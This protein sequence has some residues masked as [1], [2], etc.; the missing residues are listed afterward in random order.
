MVV[1]MVFRVDFSMLLRGYQ[2]L[3]FYCLQVQ[4]VPKSITESMRNCDDCLPNKKYIHDEPKH[5]KVI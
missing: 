2:V 5:E 4:I 3:I 1:A